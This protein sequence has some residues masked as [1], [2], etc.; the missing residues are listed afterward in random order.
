MKIIELILFARLHNM[1]NICECSKII[2]KAIKFDVLYNL[3]NNTKMAIYNS[4]L[5]DV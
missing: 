1:F 5:I 4:V 3:E 2:S